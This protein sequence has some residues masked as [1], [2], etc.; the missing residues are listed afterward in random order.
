MMSSVVVTVLK[1][2]VVVTMHASVLMVIMLEVYLVVGMFVVGLTS[3][4]ERKIG[5][6]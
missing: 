4:L 5:R 2:M 3:I 6:S 1:V